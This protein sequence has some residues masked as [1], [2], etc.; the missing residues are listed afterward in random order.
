MGRE[1]AKHLARA[2]EGGAIEAEF[3]HTVGGAVVRTLTFVGPESEWDADERSRDPSWYAVRAD[4]IVQ[5]IRVKAMGDRPPAARYPA[6]RLVP[7][8]N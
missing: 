8:S 7:S 1:R 6:E 4:G 3:T 2:T 5:A